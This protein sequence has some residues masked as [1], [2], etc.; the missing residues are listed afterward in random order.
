MLL[1]FYVCVNF[2]SET[3]DTVSCAYTDLGG[4]LLC[5]DRVLGADP[6]CTA[7]VQNDLGDAVVIRQRTTTDVDVVGG[8]VVQ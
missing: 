1:N 6:I 5:V 2:A 7:E 8:R 3:S 4:K